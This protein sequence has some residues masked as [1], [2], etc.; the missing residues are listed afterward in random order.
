MVLMGIHWGAALESGGVDGCG[1]P[2]TTGTGSM[3]D[4]PNFS[5]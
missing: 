3:L 1:I 5:K 2:G 4:S